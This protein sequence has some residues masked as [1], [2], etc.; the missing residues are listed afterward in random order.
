MKKFLKEALEEIIGGILL[1]N[2]GGI[3]ENIRE[4]ISEAILGG[5]HGTTLKGFLKDS[6]EGEPDEETL[7]AFHLGILRGLVGTVFGVERLTERV[8]KELSKEVFVETS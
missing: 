3:P 5:I 1:R 4:G 8:I 7:G 2:S 6:F